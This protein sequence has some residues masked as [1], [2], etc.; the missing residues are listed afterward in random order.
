MKTRVLYIH[1]KDGSPTE[2]EHYK[3]LFPSFEVIGLD[4]RSFTPWDA[5]EEFAAAIKGIK[6]GCDRL[7]LVANS[8]GAYYTMNASVGDLIEKAF[9]ISPIV[10]LERLILDIMAASGVSEEELKAKGLVPSAFGEDLSWEYLFYV[11][12]HPIEW[13]VPTE[14]LY[15][16]EDN[17][18]SLETVS[19]F[20]AAHGA[21]LTVMDGGEHWFHTPEQMAFLDEWIRK[22][23]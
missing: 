22:S 5:K 9:F 10:N 17:L 13:T 14:I 12:S 16:S 4:Y 8:L 15:G 21:R 3:P 18:T 2:A 23:L 19:A 7:L 11:R 6:A 20:A 1:G